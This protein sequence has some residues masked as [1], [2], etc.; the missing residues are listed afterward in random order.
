MQ[1]VTHR[2]A[3]MV[4]EFERGRACA[5]LGTVNDDEI[6]VDAGVEHRFANSHEFARLS[7]AELEADRL[8]VAE[9]AQVPDEGHEFQR[10]REGGV[11]GRRDAIRPDGNAAGFRDF[12]CHFCARQDAAMAG[13]GALAEFDLDH[14]DLRIARLRLETVG[15]ERAVGFAAA[16]I[17]AAQF[18]DEIAAKFA[19]VDR[20]TAFAGIMREAAELG[21]LVQGADCVGAERAETHRGNIENGG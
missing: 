4:G 21:T 7:D 20:N 9:F 17:A 11:T 8:A 13:F 2:H 3:D 12:R 18:P 10:R 16:E 19:V 5:P 6:W 14:F 1:S 15:I